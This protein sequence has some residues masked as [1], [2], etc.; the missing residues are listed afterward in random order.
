VRVCVCMYIS[1]K[2]KLEEIIHTHTHIFL[3]SYLKHAQT[4]IPLLTS[5]PR[6]E[7]R[8]HTPVHTHPQRHTRLPV[9]VSL[10]SL[11]SV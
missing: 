5:V 4:E 10:P 3:L 6:Q 2:V 11:K 1:K 8:T 9:D 7:R